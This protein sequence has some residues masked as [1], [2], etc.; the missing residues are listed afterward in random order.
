[1][2][3]IKSTVEQKIKIPVIEAE[4]KVLTDD[5]KNL[6]KYT[7]YLL[8]LLFESK[9]IDYIADITKFNRWQ[10]E[11]EL[12]ILS[13]YGLVH[14]EE[15]NYLIS[16]LGKEVIKRS[17]EINVFN[18]RKEKVLIDK[19]TGA[20]LNYNAEYKKIDDKKYT[21]V[22]DIFK[23]INP[24]N[25]KEYFFENYCNYFNDIDI[26]DIDVELTLKDEY[27][28]EFRINNYKAIIEA[29]EADGILRKNEI[30]LYSS[31]N[32]EELNVLDNLIVKGILYKINVSYENENINGYRNSINSLKEISAIDET[33]LSDKGKYLLG[34]HEQEEKL[35]S[36]SK[37][38]Y[39]DSISGFFNN[40]GDFSSDK[41]KRNSMTIRLDKIIQ[42]KDLYEDNIKKISGFLDKDIGEVLNQNRYKVKYEL[43]NEFEVTKE[44]DYRELYKGVG[45]C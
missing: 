8:N 3:Y 14:N 41:V 17:R 25:S 4:I 38:I 45:L 31:D 33:L 34:L 20:I 42:F 5:Y 26:E 16:N 36:C 10:I 43:E 7:Y 2:T 1:M 30:E 39:F 12:E 27:W 9:N 35:N 6:N 23:N 40:T 19:L 24:S 18:E 29:K 21:I 22:K 32:E 15:D 44:V 13:K 37:P 11:N 28:I